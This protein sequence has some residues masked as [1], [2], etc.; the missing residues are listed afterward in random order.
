MK[1]LIIFIST[2]LLSVYMVFEE[3][4]SSYIWKLQTIAYNIDDTFISFLLNANGLVL[5]L[6]LET[7]SFL[8]VLSMWWL[9][10]NSNCT[11]S[12]RNCKTI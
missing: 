3:Y 6:I 11:A 10:V 9:Y 1:Y 2:L 5:L 4:K 12:T 7:V 8:S